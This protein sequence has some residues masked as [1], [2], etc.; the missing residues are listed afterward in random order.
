ME[1][2][3]NPAALHSVAVALGQLTVTP[4]TPA[5]PASAHPVSIVAAEQLNTLNTN[6]TMLV[7]YAKLLAARAA[8][9]YTG[10]AAQYVN[11]DSAQSHAVARAK[12]ALNKSLGRP[13]VDVPPMPVPTEVPVVPPHPPEPVLLPHPPDPVAAPQPADLSAA[14][15]HTGDQGSSIT[16]LAAT[17]RT[18]A[19]ALEGYHQTLTSAANG[20]R[21]GWSGAAAEAAL[22]RLVPFADWF[23]Q[24]AKA[25]TEAAKAADQVVSAH[26]RTVADHPTP[27]QLTTLKKNLADAVAQGDVPG[28]EG[29]R[30]QLVQAQNHSTVV[31]TGYA[32][33]AAVPLGAVNPP[34]APVNPGQN[35]PPQPGKPGQGA[36]QAGPGDTP[37]GPK[38]PKKPLGKGPDSPETD[39]DGPLQQVNN[40][41]DPKSLPPGPQQNLPDGQ[42]NTPEPDPLTDGTGAPAAPSMMPMMAPLMQGLGQAAQ[43]GMPGGQGMPQMPQIP[44]M[45]MSPPTPPSAPTTPPPMPDSPLDPAGL[46]GGGAGGGGGGGGAEPAAAPPPGLTA[47]APVSAPPSPPPA[48]GPGGSVGAGMPMGMMPHGGGK[49]GGGDKSREEQLAPDEPVYVEERA[50]TEAFL[51]GSIG[52]EPP[53]EAKE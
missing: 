46:G 49:Q 7:G 40:L 22:G 32:T 28:A 12:A 50:H 21:S 14:Q 10:S 17:W 1:L 16:A 29:Y 2:R 30:Q 27:T 38:K 47:T 24:A 45:P 4:A 11:T 41:T 34:P 19:A 9:A 33:N 25:H 15:L 35:Q 42:P 51:G 13:A 36:P 3:V 39:P 6:L 43:G 18:T 8:A 5:V 26:T 53:P 37:D 31:T 44:Q 52:P 23:S 20:L 48:S